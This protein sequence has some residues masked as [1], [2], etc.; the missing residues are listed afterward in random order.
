MYRTLKLNTGKIYTV[1]VAVADSYEELAK[2][3]LVLNMKHKKEKDMEHEE[4]E[5]KDT[6]KSKDMEEDKKMKK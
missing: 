4:G 2:A 5:D 1:P 3:Q 6:K